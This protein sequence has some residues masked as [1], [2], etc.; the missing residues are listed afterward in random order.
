MTNATGRLEPGV[1]AHGS[2]FTRALVAEFTKITTLRS[3]WLG[4]VVVLALTAYFAQMG[5]SLLVDL[6]GT[7]EGGA[8]TDLDGSRVALEE[9]VL[10]TVL[11]SPYQSVALFLPLVIAIAVGQEYRGGQILTSVTAVPSRLTL[12]MAKLVTVGI[13]AA[14]MCTAAFV[15]SNAVL[16]LMLPPEAVAI[17][18]TFEALLVLPRVMLYG[19]CISVV[20]AALTGLF[21]N[22]LFALFTIVAILVLGVSGLLSAFV[23]FLHNLM[24]MIAA[25]SFLFG[26]QAEGVPSMATGVFVLLGWAVVT[27][28]LWVA[29]FTRRD[30]A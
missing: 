7:L 3:W 5:A 29:V 27:T 6:L 19:V 8:F 10:D 12:A 24:P 21:R 20:A 14:L 4:V 25:Q 23:P 22:T 28:V 1:R 15:L 16:L 26:Y 9:G 30:V 17:V 13:L 2:A 18:L 11:G